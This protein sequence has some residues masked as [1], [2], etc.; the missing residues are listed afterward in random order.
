MAARLS[1]FVPVFV[2][3]ITGLLYL[4]TLW[5]GFVWDDTIFLYESPLYRDPSRWADALRQPFI[6]SENYFRPLVLATFLMELRQWDSWTLPYHLFNTLLHALNAGLMAVIARRLFSN[7]SA[8]ALSAGLLYGIHPALVES[9]AFISSRF[10]LMVTTCLLLALWCDLKFRSHSLVLRALSV[11]L[12]FL[13]AAFAKEMA[14]AL[15]FAYPAWLL[16]TRSYPPV[17]KRPPKR[18]TSPP[19]SK[20]KKRGQRPAENEQPSLELA[21]T[22]KNALPVVIALLTTGAFYLIIRYS[23][24]GYLLKPSEMKIEAG[25]PLQHLLLVGLSASEYLKLIF[26]PFFSLNPLHA[27]ALPVPLSNPV[28]WLSLTVSVF[29]VG[30]TTWLLRKK[31]PAGAYFA[32]G[33]LALVP[34]LNLNPLELGGGAFIAERFLTFPMVFFV[35][36]VVSLMSLLPITQWRPMSFAWLGASAMVILTT[37]PHW[38][39]DYALW[40]WVV[41]R[42][43]E[44]SLPH[45]N[46]AKSAVEKGDYA[47]GLKHADIAVQ[48]DPKDSGAWNHRGLSLFFLKRFEEAQEAFQKAAELRP[49]ERLYWNNVAGALREQNKLDEAL[50]VLQEKVLNTRPAL[51]W[52]QLNA[53]IIYMRAARPDLAIP[54][55][56]A[57]AQVLPSGQK[58]D[59]LSLLEQT[60]QPAIWLM[61]GDRFQQSQ[62]DLALRAYEQATQ[63]GA[64]PVNVAIGSSAAYIYQRAWGRAEQ[65]LLEA[66]Q[67][68]PDDPR[69]Y[70]NLGVVFREKGDKMRARQNFLKATQL[71]PQ[72]DLPKQ[73]LNLLNR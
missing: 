12:C 54:L 29:A 35:L 6:F 37:L 4:P 59:A 19:T 18:A 62:P 23:A 3:L 50:K 72:W 34:V 46:L 61:M 24:L 21:G 57:A 63:L 38:K 64:N 5:H 8:L 55:L 42:S 25:S 51:P 68:A 13:I 70:N 67:L 32:A 2:A 44:S 11:S 31:S 48:L 53:G 73:N 40:D 71:N 39:N 52:G 22:Q 16:A 33:W 1:R 69:L 26:F 41:T 56:E 43:P 20:H 49:Q 58:Q 47:K 10:D 17:L 66:I 36:G 9:V 60:R 30:L 27:T 65:V 7:S 28:A 14:V 15:I 45:V